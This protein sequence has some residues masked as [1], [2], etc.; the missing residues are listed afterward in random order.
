M[1]R[2]IVLI[3]TGFTVH[4]QTLQVGVVSAA[5]M[6]KALRSAPRKNQ[7]RQQAIAG[8]FR[9][10]GC[11]PESRPV[12][13]SKFSN[14]VC[15][16]P[17]PDANVIVVGGHFD[18]ANVGDGVIDNWSGATMV[19]HLMRSLR[20]Q[21]RR[22]TFVFVAFARE[23]DGLLGSRDYVGRLTTPEVAR[24]QAM[25]N[26]DSLG[27]GP[28]VVWRSRANGPLFD[29][30]QVVAGAVHMQLNA[31]NV[32]Q[33][34]ETDSAPFKEKKIAVIDFHSIHNDTFHILHP[35]DDNFS[36]VQMDGYQDSFKLIANFLVYI[37]LK[38]P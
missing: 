20:S 11:E 1:N 13:R 38:L 21:P 37:D 7:V 14:V 29:A 34:G 31:V 27:L 18:H 36:A 16:Q 12:K 5:E 17:G 9:D 28:P 33:V 30:S 35:R 10:S 8:M 2:V 23:E 32:D 25:V 15:T 4:A 26:M 22:H 3:L 24:I 19:V 6:E